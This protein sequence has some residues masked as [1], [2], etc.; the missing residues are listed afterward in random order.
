MAEEP[1]AAG[2]VLADVTANAIAAYLSS[3]GVGQGNSAAVLHRVWA[4][5]P[6]VRSAWRWRWRRRTSARA[7]PP[8]PAYWTCARTSRR[9]PRRSTGGRTRSPSSSPR[10]RRAAVPQPGEVAAGARGGERA[11]HSLRRACDSCARAPT[12]DDAGAPTPGAPKLAVETMAIFF[13]TLHAGAG[14]L[15]PDL[16][17]E[18]QG[19]AAAAA[20]AHPARRRGGG[21]LRRRRAGAVPGGGGAGGGGAGG[22]AGGSSPRTSR[23]RPTPTSSGST[24]GRGRRSRRRRCWLGSARRARRARARRLRVHGAQP[25]RRVPL[26]LQVPG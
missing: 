17:Q 20:R 11:R 19:V 4:S 18:L 1:A 15:P 22:S 8:C 14:G 16:R 12:G 9:S 26:L 10:W 21:E 13:K 7:G 23:R 24:R 2:G 6:G 5:G 25:V 3:S